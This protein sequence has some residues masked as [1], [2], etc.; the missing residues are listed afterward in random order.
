MAFEVMSSAKVVAKRMLFPGL[1]LH[2][3]CRQRYLPRL[4]RPGPLQTLDA[5]S[6][7]GAL[8]LAAYRLGNRVLGVT[9][10]EREARETTAFFDVLHIPRTQVEIRQFNIYELRKLDRSFDQIICSETLEHLRR[11]DEVVRIFAN[12]LRPGGRLVLCS[13]YARHPE[14][15]QGRTNQPEDG[16]HVRDGYTIES[17]RRLLEPA[18]FRIRRAMGLGSPLLCRLNRPLRDLRK[19]P[20]GDVLALPL[21]LLSVPLTWLDRVNPAVPY[22]LAV[23]AEKE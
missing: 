6:G 8:S 1:D 22:S 5:G 9:F 21:F 14:H 4:L 13:P 20:H 3:R 12:L 10:N 11:D 19:R 17:Y 15:A 2:T 23:V 7:N 18:G 16:G